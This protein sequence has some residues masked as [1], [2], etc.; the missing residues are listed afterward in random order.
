MLILPTKYFS[1]LHPFSIL[2]SS[3]GLSSIL[4]HW[5]PQS[6]KLK[7]VHNK[8]LEKIKILISNNNHLMDGML[9][10]EKLKCLLL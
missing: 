6:C 8:M 7:I 5:S 3:L 10:S 1:T 4:P 2:Y 9:G